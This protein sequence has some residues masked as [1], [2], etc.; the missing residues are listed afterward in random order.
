MLSVRASWNVLV[1]LIHQ[2]CPQFERLSL[3]RR[4]KRASY[5]VD[6]HVVAYNARITVST[7]PLLL[8]N[9]GSVELTVAG[10][11]LSPARDFIRYPRVWGDSRR[12]L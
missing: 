8:R 2:A 12:R 11:G 10:R 3:P 4:R 7:E 6:G 1:E 9:Y 5:P